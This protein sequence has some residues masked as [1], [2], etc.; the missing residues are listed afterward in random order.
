MEDRL[1]RESDLGGADTNNVTVHLVVACEH[2]IW[3]HRDW[4]V[5][6]TPT[7]QCSRGRQGDKTE[8]KRDNGR[9]G[10]RISFASVTDYIHHMMTQM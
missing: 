7:K 1:L 8:L 2:G 3:M 6:A 5:M 10:A 4:V 9:F